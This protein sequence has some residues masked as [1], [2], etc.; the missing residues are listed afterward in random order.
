MDSQLNGSFVRPL[1]LIVGA[2]Y[3]KV[4]VYVSIIADFHITSTKYFDIKIFS[5]KHGSLHVA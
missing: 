2:V 1:L 4:K 5:V 3:L